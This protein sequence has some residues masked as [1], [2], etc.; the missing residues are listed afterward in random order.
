MA[1][2]IVAGVVGD[3]HVR[4]SFDWFTFWRSF[5]YPPGPGFHTYIY[6]KEEWL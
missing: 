3:V 6:F 2:I 4:V 1:I 5:A